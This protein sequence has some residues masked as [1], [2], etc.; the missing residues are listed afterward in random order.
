[1][2]LSSETLTAITH[3]LKN[4]YAPAYSPDGKSIAFVSD[5]NSKPALF[6]RGAEG[7]ETEQQLKILKKLGCEFGQGYLFSRPLSASAA[8]QAIIHSISAIAI[9]D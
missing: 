2:E 5:R 1:M 7:V 3:D 8:E 6:I 9:L 4:D